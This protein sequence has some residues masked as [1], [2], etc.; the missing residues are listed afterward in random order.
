MGIFIARPPMI[1]RRIPFN[2]VR[3]RD[4]FKVF[5]QIGQLE[6][7]SDKPLFQVRFHDTHF[8]NSRLNSFSVKAKCVSGPSSRRIDSAMS[9]VTGARMLKWVAPRTGEK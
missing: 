6:I 4:P 1:P 9:R 5:A 8:V 3:L 2:P 7:N